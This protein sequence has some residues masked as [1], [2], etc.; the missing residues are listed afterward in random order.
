[1]TL[2]AQ[3]SGE[4]LRAVERTGQD[5]CCSAGPGSGKTRVLVA[6]FLWLVSQGVDPQSI[7]AITFTEKATREIR[8]RLVDAFASD[9]ARRRAAERAPV[10]TID[11]F[12]HSILRAHALSAGLDPEFRVLDER[13]AYLEQ[14]AAMEG[15]LDHFAIQHRERFLA[16]LEHW[17][18]P[19]YKIPSF[20]LETYGRIRQHGGVS[21]A[22]QSRHL[23]DLQGVL[24]RLAQIG[25]DALRESSGLLTTPAQ[26]DRAAKLRDWL[27]ARPALDPLDWLRSF[28]IDRKGSK[29]G[30]PLFEGILEI[31]EL[32][33]TAR[34]AAVSHRFTAEAQ[35]LGDLLLDFERAYRERKRQLAAVDFSDLGEMA[36]DLLLTHRDVREALRERYREVLMDELQDT[37]PVQ[38]QVVDLV[39]SPCHFFAVGDINQSIYAFRQAEP[40]IFRQFRDGIAQ[41]GEVDRLTRNYRSRTEILAVVNAVTPLLGG[42]EPH[43]LRGGPE[44]PSGLHPCVEL[45][46]VEGTETN[47]AAWVADRVQQLIEEGGCK[48]DEIAILARTAKRFGEFQ[49][50]LLQRGIRCVVKRGR[51]FFEEPEVVDLINWLRVLDNPEDEIALVGLLRSPFFAVP[52]EEI[53]H[54]RLS[55]SLL[56]D[57]IQQARRFR[58]EIPPDRILAQMVDETGYLSRLTAGGQANVD[59]FFSWMRRLHA[60]DPAD[61][62]AWLQA[63]AEL[64]AGGQENCAPIGEARAVELLTVHGAKGLEWPVVF[65]VEMDRVPGG[66]TP[67]LL[68]APGSGLGARWDLGERESQPDASYIAAQQTQAGRARNEE[69]RLLYVAMTRAEQRLVMTW[70]EGAKA[71]SWAAVVE[72]ALQPAWPETPFRSL[73]VGPL[74][75]RHVQGVPDARFSQAASVGSSPEFAW[76]PLPAVLPLPTQISVTAL[77]HFDECP[78]R[79]YLAQVL[80]WPAPAGEGAGFAMALGT[81]VHDLLGGLREP[82][83]VSPEAQAL[84]EAFSRSELGQRAACARSAGREFDFLAELGG[85]LVQGSVDL[86]F[87]DDKGLVLV[88]YKSD[89]RLDAARLAAYRKQLQVYAA[90]LAKRFRRWPDEAY[91]FLLREDRA[92]PIELRAD[93]VEAAS[94]IAGYRDACS[95]GEFPTRPA[96]HCAWCPFAEGACPELRPAALPA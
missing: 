31:K 73:V 27:D 84:A 81:E 33:Q 4:Q 19:G 63:I 50:E 59:K 40:A 66:Q 41:Q 68:W 60:T 8:T 54:R 25:E 14:S 85:L 71:G 74:S 22:L 43:E 92:I 35:L 45:L 62:S 47:E 3:L 53:F 79:H 15:V 49:Q 96:A 18:A 38:W 58:G 23:P 30:H 78:R 17:A 70:R 16:L 12:C 65:L 72:A 75:L 61:Y 93:D 89:A 26:R 28:Q 52:D 44:P 87:E 10:Y 95:R 80:H 34:Q 55:G 46:R 13:E 77:V 37:S 90:A 82:D 21:L 51:N 39:R 9:P 6:R 32:L 57:R 76:Q 2:L 29:A 48:P 67:P 86:W 36:R 1:M 91:L 24:H 69:D 42:V 7:L 88:D 20:L 83:A 64:R 11:G 94:W 5:A 56:L